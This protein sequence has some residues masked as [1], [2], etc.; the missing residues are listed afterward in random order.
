MLLLCFINLETHHGWSHQRLRE[1]HPAIWVLIAGVNKK[2]EINLISKEVVVRVENVLTW[3]VEGTIVERNPKA[4]II[5]D[6]Y[7]DEF[8]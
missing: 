1:G 2:K 8:I 6:S 4:E 5:A 3:H 7:W